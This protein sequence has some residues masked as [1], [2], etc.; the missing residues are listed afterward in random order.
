MAGPG[1]QRLQAK[2]VP[3]LGQ[4]LAWP[5]LPAS[6]HH[7]RRSSWEMPGCW[8]KEHRAARGTSRCDS[9]A[10]RRR[11]LGGFLLLGPL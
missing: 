7:V 5:R 9:L 1:W 4:L 6:Q 11:R 8:F 10:P 3:R 2:P